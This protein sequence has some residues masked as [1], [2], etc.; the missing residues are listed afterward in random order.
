[1]NPE[2]EYD[3]DPMADRSLAELWEFIGQDPKAQLKNSAY[4][5]AGPGRYAFH[6]EGIGNDLTDAPGVWVAANGGGLP[7]PI[8]FRL[9]KGRGR[10]VV[11]GLVVG[12]LGDHEIT[13]ETLRSI[14]LSEVLHALFENFD[15]ANPPQLPPGDGYGW[16][17]DEASQAGY[18]EYIAYW[19]FKELV[20]DSAPDLPSAVAERDELTEFA[21]AYLRNLMSQPHRA[22]QATADNLIISRATANRRAQKCRDIGLLPPR[23]DKSND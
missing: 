6:I 5:N 13:S 7:C 16:K 8:R 2:I 20:F 12:E 14:K 10:I 11:T 1:M 17:A 23:V 15:P 4:F 3:E 19:L 22:M 21:A 9:A 18:D